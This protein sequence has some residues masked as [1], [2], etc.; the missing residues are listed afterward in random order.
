MDRVVRQA[1][2][3][4]QLT[5]KILAAF[6]AESAVMAVGLVRLAAEAEAAPQGQLGL[7]ALVQPETRQAALTAAA[8]A[9]AQT[10]GLPEMACRHRAQRA[11]MAVRV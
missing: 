5:V 3:A 4:M 8:A 9:A 6:S 11:A 2:V 7:A 10:T 1:T